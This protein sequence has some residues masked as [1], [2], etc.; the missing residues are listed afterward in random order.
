M[1]IYKIGRHTGFTQRLLGRMCMMAA[2]LPALASCVYDGAPCPEQP[3]DGYTINL[4]ISTGALATRSDGDKIVAGSDAEN[5]IDIAGGDYAVFIFDGD[6]RFVQR[7]EPGA[8]TLVQDGTGTQKYKLSGAF[9]PQ[10][11]L[12]AIQL[13]VLANCHN[14]FGASYNIIEKRFD[15]KTLTDIYGNGTDFNFKMPTATA[16]DGTTP[17]DGTTSTSWQPQEGASGIPMFG[18]SE[19]MTLDN[20]PLLNFEKVIPMLRSIAKVEIVDNTKDGIT[21]VSL[22]KINS[23]GRIIPDVTKNAEWAVEKS[24]VT[25]PSLPDKIEYLENIVF[26]NEKRTVDNAEKSVWVAYIP[27]MNLSSAIRDDKAR[28]T[29]TV[30]TTSGKTYTGVKF[31]NYRNGEQVTANNL[32]YVLRNHIYHYEVDMIS[33]QLILNLTVLPWDFKP[34]EDVWHMDN[35]TVK[36]PEKNE[37]T[38]E[39]TRFYL[40]WKLTKMVDD[41]EVENGCKDNQEDLQLVMMGGTDDYVEGT[42]TLSAPLNAK[43]YATLVPLHGPTD[44]FSFMPN[45]DSGTIDGSTEATIRIKNT[46]EKVS[47]QNNEA[48]L[49]IMVEYPDKTRKEAIVVDPQYTVYIQDSEG[50]VTTETKEDKTRRNYTIVQ[51]MTDITGGY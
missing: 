11:E 42:F 20:N 3:D 48:R 13:M 43:W 7:F 39:E 19:K 46:Y 25:T 4:T 50:N 8:V 37:E 29:F 45:Y 49:V 6:G 16:A 31:D 12:N 38:G 34:E 1:D 23:N 30:Q 5:F 47:G 24:Q 14:D 51:E 33:A 26:F 44:A 40:K 35:P 32:N 9:R 18:L 17:A 22:S 27:E 21:S 15:T 10:S 41:E 36:E 28:P 2:F